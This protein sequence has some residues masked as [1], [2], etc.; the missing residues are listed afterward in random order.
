MRA[1]FVM[2][3]VSV[4]LGACSRI[5][6]PD[7]QELAALP[8][9][10]AIDLTQPGAPCDPA[11]EDVL[12]LLDPRRVALHGET[13]AWRSLENRSPDDVDRYSGTVELVEDKLSPSDIE[14]LQIRLLGEKY[15]AATLN[16]DGVRLWLIGE[17]RS[18]GVQAGQSFVAESS[19]RREQGWNWDTRLTLT[20]EGETVLHYEY[21]G[22]PED[23]RLP[24]DMRAEREEFLCYR[25]GLSGGDLYSLRV[26]NA[27]G[28]SVVL[29]PGQAGSLGDYDVYM[30][31]ALYPQ[32]GYPT[33]NGTD[34][35]TAITEIAAA[36]R[37]FH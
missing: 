35:R 28:E 4:F 27:V 31:V 11:A 17:M 19:R 7:M 18:L 29:R 36:R 14:R 9:P 6:G 8:E 22:F 2:L 12:E 33:L 25:D 21:A 16:I 30:W 10:A 1:S 26:T 20:S 37:V 32:D 24:D 23:L 3:T 34:T 5:H 15:L 13:D